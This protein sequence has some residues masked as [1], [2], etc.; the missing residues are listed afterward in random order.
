MDGS[1]IHQERGSGPTGLEKGKSICLSLNVL[2]SEVSMGHP[3]RDSEWSENRG[4][5]LRRAVWAA[6]R[7]P[8]VLS[9]HEGI[10]GGFCKNWTASTP[11]SEPR[12][13]YSNGHSWNANTEG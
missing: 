5:V 7:D 12:A 10:S 13:G 2:S 1:A 8:Q 6:D 9:T 4:L 11:Q 3:S